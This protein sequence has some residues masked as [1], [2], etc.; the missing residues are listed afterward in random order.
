MT[1][2]GSFRRPIDESV[3]GKPLALL[4]DNILEDLQQ[5]P[6]FHSADACLQES[7]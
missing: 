1:R 6:Q 7:D 4:L 2:T 5:N 3:A